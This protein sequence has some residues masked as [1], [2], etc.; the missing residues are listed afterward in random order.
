M[1][2]QGVEGVGGGMFN[3]LMSWESI[4]GPLHATHT[5]QPLDM[6]HTGERMGP[7]LH[8][9]PAAPWGCRQGDGY[10]GIGLRQEQSALA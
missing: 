10:G 4:L 1:E 5:H 7:T 3:H 6:R 9:L 2:H 8:T